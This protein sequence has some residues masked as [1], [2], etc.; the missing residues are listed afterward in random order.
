MMNRFLHY[1]IILT[2]L[3]IA[4][5][6]GPSAEIGAESSLQKDPANF[7]IP[8]LVDAL[9]EDPHPT[10]LYV[11]VPFPRDW[12]VGPVAVV[13]EKGRRAPSSSRVMARWPE[14]E[15]V[16]WMGVD[17]LGSSGSQYFVVP[18]RGEKCAGKT[19]VQVEAKAEGLEVRT[20]PAR[21]F[22]PAKGA[23]IREAWVDLD[24]DGSWGAGEL[25]LQN[26]A[27]DDLY[28]VNQAGELAVIG[29][30]NGD[31]QLTYETGED[32]RGE[33]DPLVKAV[34]KRE[35]WYVT[36][37][38]ER[39]ARHVTR[40]VFYAGSSDFKVEHALVISN[41]TGKVWFREYGLRLAYSESARPGRVLVPEGEGREAAVLAMP[42]G[43]AL[44][45]V[46]LFQEKAFSFS[47]TD[48]DKDCRFEI[49]ETLADGTA[50]IRK[51]GSLAGNWMEASN[52]RAA[53]GVV[54][55]NLWQTFP[56]E[57][58]TTHEAMTVRLW[59]PRGG[60]E[61]D[62][63]PEQVRGRWPSEWF[64]SYAEPALKTRIRKM[65]TN[66]LGLA[67]SHEMTVSLAPTGSEDGQRMA[68][69]GALAQEQVL[70]LVDPAWLRFSEAMGK[71][72]P[73]DPKRFPN[74]E[75]FMEEWFD[76][77]VAVWRQWGD[78]GFFEFGNW[79]HVWYRQHPKG[80]L[81]G[82]W[83]PYVDRYSAILDY[84]FYANI[85]RMYARTGKRKYFHA[86]EETS[87]HRLDVGM[88]HWD[89]LQEGE[90]WTFEP[91]QRAPTR[92]LGTYVSSNS[93]IPWAARSSFHHNSGT[94]IRSLAW[95][96]HLLDDRRAKDMLSSYGDAAKKVWNT[97]ERG[98][99]RN[100]RPFATLKNLATIYQETGDPEIRVM[101]DEQV[102]WLADLE[103]PQGVGLER[104]TTGFGKYGVKAGA[105]HRANEASGNE[106]AGQSVT[107]G[108]DT[109]ARTFMGENPMQYANVEGEQLSAA[110]RLTGDP[111]FLRA[112]RR[113]MNLAVSAFRDPASG[114]WRKMWDGV[115]PSAA[116]NTYPL[117]GMA[118]AMD[119]IAE[120]EQSTGQKV[121]ATP[122]VR[123]GDF[124]PVT[125]AVVE[126]V[127]G[128]PLEVEV[129]SIHEIQ[130]VIYDSTG[131]P[132][133]GVKAEPWRDQFHTKEKAATRW[134]LELPA[135]LPAGPYIVDSGGRGFMWEVTWASTDRA[136]LFAPQGFALGS[137]ERQWGNRVMPGY[138]HSEPVFFLV[139]KG[140]ASF[141]IAVSNGPLQLRS[142][143]GET[144]VCG[145]KSRTWQTIPVSEDQQGKI[146]S[147]FADRSVFV[148]LKGVP[149]FFAYGQADRFFQP[150]LGADAMRLLPDPQDRATPAREAGPFVKTPSAAGEPQEGL[151]LSRVRLQVPS[152]D[153]IDPSGGTMEMWL[154]PRWNSVEVFGSGPPRTVMDGG[155]WK[156]LLHRFGE[157][158]ATATVKAGPGSPKQGTDLETN[159]GV[160]LT[161]GQW[162]HLALQWRQEGGSFRWELLVNGRKQVFGISEAGMATVAAGFVPEPP[163]ED[164]VFGGP[165][166]GRANLDAILGG[167]RFSKGARYKEHF[168]PIKMPT[169]KQDDQTI[170]LILFSEGQTGSG[171]LLEK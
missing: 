156:V 16:R 43:S 130:P 107:R 106:L 68:K 25:V 89:K 120:Y 138:S 13:D 104:E 40:L 105:M 118:Y 86:A 109:R 74:E 131:K 66:A 59:S 160:A 38:G 51:S 165:A 82:R 76:Q 159:A 164:L 41:D 18:E 10:A 57:I 70:C 72:H 148:R 58:L 151:L 90:P 139:P 2:I 114:A 103:A 14:S 47:K 132:A 49:T 115:G 48:P 42:F 101:M 144:L 27:G 91:W 44:R 1:R 146:W 21:F 92:F 12:T 30:D 45:E 100:S 110:Y 97:G 129:R 62:F 140:I 99:F 123:Q 153:V 20:G 169:L 88:V 81:Q 142:P 94:D 39:M 46:S 154:M 143:S 24:G 155:P 126:K 19:S 3:V 28:L 122:F 9:A 87:R 69:L 34:V 141:E 63:R 121:A 55:R 135:A 166:K 36:E 31:G 152:K 37:A 149:P 124:G 112:L 11:G 52:E 168:D 61:L 65:D 137:S 108:A 54:L 50:K 75:A 6:L 119:A 102:K 7:R 98:S 113:S 53:V 111:V 73:Y 84:G 163:A 147:V 85:W 5:W 96:S 127:E 29:R 79:P 157:M 33:G 128:Q 15:A 150:E 162:T 125:L 145:E 77:H 71:M 23:L 4:V 80:P 35:G 22:L 136:V 170:E 133:L 56:K 95:R 60:L 171:R 167:L 26:T 116:A 32:L 78:Y 67:R 64:E 93:P 8:I 83:T 17:F 161:P 158:A 117:G 134:I